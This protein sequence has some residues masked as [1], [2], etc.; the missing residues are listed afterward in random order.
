[1]TA[2]LCARLRPCLDIVDMIAPGAAVQ[3]AQ[4]SGAARS[5]L[6]QRGQR[7]AEMEGGLLGGEKWAG[8]ARCLRAP[9]GV[10]HRSE[11]HTSE[12]QSLMRISYAVFCL[13]KKITICAANTNK[14]TTTS[15]T[16]SQKINSI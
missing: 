7:Q 5:H 16:R 3:P 11:E 15:R 13:T 9:G 6:L 1:M 4:R 14:S 10:V 12:L 8:L 2:A